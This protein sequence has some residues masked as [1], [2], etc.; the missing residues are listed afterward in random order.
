MLATVCVCVCR[1]SGGGCRGW[2]G[3]RRCRNGEVVGANIHV[4]AY[5][6]GRVCAEL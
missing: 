1:R 6:Y 3:G 4:L 2:L 5:E